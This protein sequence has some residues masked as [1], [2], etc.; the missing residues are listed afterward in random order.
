MTSTEDY[1]PNVGVHLVLTN[2]HGQVLLLQRANTGFADGDWSIPGGRLDN[3]E[4][5]PAGAAREALEEI[6]IRIEP[7]HLAFS[8]LCHHADSDG[9]QRIGVFFTTSR[10]TGDIVNA[11]PDRCSALEWFTPS[12][13]PDNTVGYIRQGIHATLTGPASLSLHGWPQ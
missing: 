9:Q 11:E 4:P 8:H 1:R 10:W 7:D 6:G 3:G 2:S 13:L 12:D 5:L